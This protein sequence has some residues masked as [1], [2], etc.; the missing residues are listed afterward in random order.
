MFETTLKYQRAGFAEPCGAVI[1]MPEPGVISK[2]KVISDSAV[3]N[4]VESY[5]QVLRHSEKEILFR[6]FLL[7]H[8]NNNYF[9]ETDPRGIF[10]DDKESLKKLV[11]ENIPEDVKGQYW[12]IN[13]KKGVSYVKYFSKG[14]VDQINELI[15]E[16]ETLEE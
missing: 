10:I 13:E 2:R 8:L 3:L 7:V 14:R 1:P 15:S 5:A 9:K 12:R 6:E 4:A 11:R 16:A